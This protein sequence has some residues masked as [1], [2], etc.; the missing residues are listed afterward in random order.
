MASIKYN[1]DVPFMKPMNHLARVACTD[2]FI[3]AS[4]KGCDLLAT[5]VLK[6]VNSYLIAL[7]FTQ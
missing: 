7:K 2:T 5:I 1:L 6:I 3:T 4:V